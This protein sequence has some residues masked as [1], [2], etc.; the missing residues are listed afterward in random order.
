M[1]PTVDEMAA[2]V[3]GI[4]RLRLIHEAFG[5]VRLCLR[6]DGVGIGPLHRCTRELGHD[7]EHLSISAEQPG[8]HAGTMQGGHPDEI[9]RLKEQTR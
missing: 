6:N 1:T 5:N 3:E 8:H 4:K 9:A 7:G 2:I